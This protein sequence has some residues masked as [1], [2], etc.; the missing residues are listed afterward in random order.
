[1]TPSLTGISS[2]ATRQVLA[3]GLSL[4]GV[5]AFTR[6]CRKRIDGHTGD[7]IGASQQLCESAYLLTLAML[8]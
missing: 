5:S 3:N 4:L 2:M 8:L 7:T 6:H 1:M